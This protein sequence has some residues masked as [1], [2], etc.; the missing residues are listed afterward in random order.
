MLCAVLALLAP[1]GPAAAQAEPDLQG[2]WSATLRFGPDIRGPLIIYRTADGGG[3]RADIAG[4]SI[5]VRIDSQSVRS[6][7]PEGRGG[8]GVRTSTKRSQGVRFF[9][10]LPDG[11]GSLRDGFWIQP[12]GYATPVE[13]VRDGPNRWRG[14]V[15]PLENRLTFYLPIT[16]Q[17]DGTY[18]TYLRNPERNA[19]VFTPVQRIEVTGNAVRLIGPRGRNGPDTTLVEGR[20]EDGVITLPL[21]GGTY[22][23]TRVSDSTSS[24]FYPRG[25]SPPR[26][27]YTVPLQLDDGWPVASPESVGMSRAAIERV[28]QMLI[29][30]PMD[31]LS[32]V[33]I[34]SL[35]MARHGKL[36][37]EEYFHGASRDQPHDLRSAAKSWTA[38]LIGAAMQAGVPLRLNTPVYRTM[39]DS[40]PAGLDPRKRAMTLEHLLTMT[41]GFNCDP[42]DTTSADEDV[43]DERGIVDWYAYTLNVPLISAPG[44]KI[45][46][47]S[48]EP[49]LAGGM[50]ARVARESQLSMFDRLLGRPLRMRSYYLGLRT[51]DAYGGGGHRFTSRDFLK[52]AQ[53][54]LNGGRWNGRQI[55]SA[56]WARRSTA[57]LRNLTPTQQYGYL[58]NS[59]QYPYQGGPDGKVRGF[60]AGGNG[61]QISMAVPDL[62]LVIVFTG[63]NYNDAAT[64]RAQRD[65]VPEW[66]LPTVNAR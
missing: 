37:V 6:P 21:R 44:E 49:N 52:L 32:T 57:A 30:M 66:L 8:Q 9:F 13:L 58:W 17:A 2:L 53:L 55:V 4:F 60:F 39:L 41:A 7:S 42:N 5:P 47:C 20:Y 18:R 59:M 12:Q 10:E 22:G 63:G 51:G 29:D 54:M 33:Q 56:E 16:R 23:F 31:S 1:S 61:G 45:F 14:T 50:L 25:Q 65:F 28:V 40:V 11:K 15:V 36:V 62:D 48:T 27:H 24:A 34:H 46:Y 64:F 43:M 19:G 26:Y 3:W 35:L 38:T